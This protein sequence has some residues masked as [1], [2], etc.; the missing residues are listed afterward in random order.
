MRP[1]ERMTSRADV[2]FRPRASSAIR[3]GDREREQAADRLAAHAA[4]G[5]LT[6]EELEGRLERV[7]AAV[8]DRDLAAVE[9]DL[10]AARRPRG[11]R[12]PPPPLALVLLAAAVLGSVLIRRPLVPLFVLALIVWQSRR[13]P[14]RRPPWRTR[15]LP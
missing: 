6:L 13:A 3:V 10:P 14:W 8:F 12:R 2:I 5:R 7:H 11:P 1:D 4:A 15:T 9:A